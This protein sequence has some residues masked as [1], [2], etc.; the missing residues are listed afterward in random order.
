[1]FTDNDFEVLL[2]ATE[3]LGKNQLRTID[4]AKTLAILIKELTEIVSKLADRINTL[5][6]DKPRNWQDQ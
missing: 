5:E 6:R 1:M 3:Q 2:K 4:D